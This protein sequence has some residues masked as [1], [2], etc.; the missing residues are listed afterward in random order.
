MA[1]ATAATQN[2]LVSAR[3]DRQ[4]V[5]RTRIPDGEGCQQRIG[6]GVDAVDDVIG[7]ADLVQEAIAGV[8]A[9]LFQDQ[10]EARDL[11]DHNVIFGVDRGDNGQDCKQAKLQ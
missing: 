9:G 6:F 10:A 8:V 2:R 7:A 11:T 4:P 3:V 1:S 5:G